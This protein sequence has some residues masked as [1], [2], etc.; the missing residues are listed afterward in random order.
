M[1]KIVSVEDEEGPP[2]SMTLKGKKKKK[3]DRQTQ[4]GNHLE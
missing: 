2:K 3:R 1:K 4:L